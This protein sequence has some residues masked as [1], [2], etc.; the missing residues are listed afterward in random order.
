MR[1]TV[2]ITEEQRAELLRLAARR[3]LKG[4]SALIQE[5]LDR[6]LAEQASREGAIEAALALKGSLGNDEA[7]QLAERTKSIREAWR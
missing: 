4:F 6:Y 3:R 5:A 7:D 1:T 2:E